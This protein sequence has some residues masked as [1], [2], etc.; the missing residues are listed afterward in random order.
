MHL[1][2]FTF[3]P[4]QGFISASRRPR[5]LFTASFILSYLTEQVIRSLKSDL[6]ELIY[7]QI[8]ESQSENLANYPN[9]IVA[10]V[11]EENIGSKAEKKFKEIW[12]NIYSSVLNELNLK[13]EVK[14]QFEKQAENYF[15]VFSVCIPFVDKED[16]Q[17]ILG[18]IDT[19]SINAKSY[20]YTYDLAERILGAKKSWRPYRGQIDDCIYEVEKD[21]K[22]VKVFPNGCTMCGERLHLA[23]D[24]KHEN[25]TKIFDEKDI[26]HIRKGEKL[27]GVC[28]TK[29]FAVKYYFESKLGSDLWHY[30]ST[31]EIAGI[32]FKVALAKKLK[33]DN[34]EKNI[35][36]YVNSVMEKF[37]IKEYN[38]KEEYAPYVLRKKPLEDDYYICLDAELFR[39]DGWEG[40]FKDM[41]FIL[42]KDKAEKVKK[43]VIDLV[44]KIKENYKLEHKN[45][46]YAILISDG[47]SVGDWLGIK[48]SIRKGILSDCFH[49]K[50][51]EKLSEY[52]KGVYEGWK[53][54]YP[55]LTIYAGGD[56][57]MALMH[58]FDVVA[59]S[60]ICNEKFKLALKELAREDKKP[61]ISAGILIT[62][63]KMSLQKA[64]NETRK[65]EKKAKDVE[66]KASACVGVLTRSGNMTSFIA[67]WED[68]ELYEELVNAFRKRDV[69]SSLAYEIRNLERYIPEDDIDIF[70][71]L[72]SRALK[73]KT[74]RNYE[75]EQLFTQMECF[76][77]K[78]R[79]YLKD[80]PITNFV[81]LLYVAR[82]VGTMREVELDETI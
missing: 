68:I 10:L 52:A 15:N 36:Q 11:E 38:R 64:I 80:S 24:W 76:I 26:R 43:D 69:S 50:F 23:I 3:S 58:P 22:R 70:L 13:N 54:R 28:L 57:L 71:S 51:S 62:H 39:K 2:I 34:N 73:K 75:W 66:G 21:S 30:P 79:H 20:G 59:Y 14:E 60:K 17:N 49:K 46:Y 82:F 56:D 25:L 42:G 77:K 8:N 19:E 63:A 35:M 44:N 40:L 31:E 16:W 18:L 41:E 67:K 72:L 1:L 55:R 37:K 7:P 47:D 61:S 45:P 65:L 32:K 48:S 6:K 33:D 5:D 78:T 81:N 53:N 9:R 74:S 12:R 4:V 29:R 27:C